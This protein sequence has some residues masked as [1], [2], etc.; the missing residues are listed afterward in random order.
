[1]SL[2]S[3]LD[4]SGEIMATL[5]VPGHSMVSDSLWALDVTFRTP[6]FMGF[7]R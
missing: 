4:H 5:R 2:T 7:Y 3:E 1:M 6:L